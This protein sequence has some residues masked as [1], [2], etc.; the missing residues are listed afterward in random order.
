MFFHTLRRRQSRLKTLHKRRPLLERLEERHLLSAAPPSTVGLFG[1]ALNDFQLR[2]SNARGSANARFA[3]G[4]PASGLV[5]VAG[6]FD[7]DRLDT[8]GV[9]DPGQNR[10]QLRNENGAG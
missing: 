5:P 9:F 10:F 2:Y 7:G 3:F 8:V 4:S 6:D 1:P